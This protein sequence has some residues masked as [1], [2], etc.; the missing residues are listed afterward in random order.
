MLYQRSYHPGKKHL[1]KSIFRPD[2]E[3]SRIPARTHNVWAT[4]A[5]RLENLFLLFRNVSVWV[6]RSKT[7][8]ES[9]LSIIK[10]KSR[11]KSF[12]SLFSCNRVM[13]LLKNETYVTSYFRHCLHGRGFICNGIGFDAVTPF[14][15]TAPVAFKSGA[16]SKRYGFI[17]RENGETASI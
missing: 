8:W 13:C 17:G 10:L 16:S 12:F 3:P 4:I 2:R 11:T 9:S 5:E 6:H 7:L 15:Y 14:V 1:Q